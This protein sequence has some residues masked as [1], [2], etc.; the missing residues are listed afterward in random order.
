MECKIDYKRN[1]W[2]YN[3]VD[4]FFLTINKASVEIYKLGIMAKSCSPNTHVLEV[5]GRS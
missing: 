5:G 2:R 1:V 4:S 3:Y